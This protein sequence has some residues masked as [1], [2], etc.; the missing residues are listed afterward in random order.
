MIYLF[1]KAIFCPKK[2]NVNLKM[3]GSE[4]SPLE[5]HISELDQI[6]NMDRIPNYSVFENFTNTEY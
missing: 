2:E 4:K 3:F 1:L 5:Y 6:V